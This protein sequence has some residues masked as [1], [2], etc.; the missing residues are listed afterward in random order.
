M[1]TFT[2]GVSAAIVVGMLVWFAIDTIKSSK[3]IKQLE[4]QNE[5]IWLEIQHRCDSIERTLDEMIRD[6]NSRVDNNFKYTDSRFD[7]FANVI[8]R[9]YVSKIDKASNTISYNN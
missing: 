9:D 1:I 6:V 8:E 3:R 4:K 7:K 5:Q 2:L